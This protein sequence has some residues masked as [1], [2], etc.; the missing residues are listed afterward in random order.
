MGYVVQKGNC[1]QEPLLLTDEEMTSMSNAKDDNTFLLHNEAIDI[2][3]GDD[4][5]IRFVGVDKT[6]TLVLSQTSFT[7]LTRKIK[8]A[9]A[10][11][12]RDKIKLRMSL[13]Q[14]QLK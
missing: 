3:F 9:V 11:S 10:K 13:I 1:C 4:V 12:K 6:V 7:C 2:L 8:V 14:E 5:R